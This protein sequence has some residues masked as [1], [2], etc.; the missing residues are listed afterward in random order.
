M[1]LKFVIFNVNM[2]R[3][4]LKIYY[5]NEFLLMKNDSEHFQ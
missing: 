4:Y 2:F 1:R 5:A 3:L